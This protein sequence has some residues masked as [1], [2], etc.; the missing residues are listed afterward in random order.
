MALCC[1]AGNAQDG[2]GDAHKNK[3]EATQRYHREK[4]FLDLLVT[5]T[6]LKDQAAFE[7]HSDA[8]GE[9]E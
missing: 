7:T 4:Y 8:P 1:C 9:S 3:M 6:T 2:G 5:M